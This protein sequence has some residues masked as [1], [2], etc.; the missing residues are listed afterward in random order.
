MA[1]SK[2]EYVKEF[3]ENKRILPNSYFVVRIDG[4]GFTKFSQVHKFAKP[5]DTNALALMTACASYVMKQ[6][7]DI[8]FAYG[9]S[10]EY[11]FLFRR[12][13]DLWN[14]R[15]MKIAGSIVS[16]FSAR[17][18]MNWESRFK[19][20]PL[21]STPCF[22]TRVVV[23]PTKNEVRDYFSWRQADCHVNNLY[24]YCFWSLVNKGGFTKNEAHKKLMG[25]L[26]KDKN[27]LL[28]S[29]YGINYSKIPEIERKGTSLIRH[30]CS[31]G[32]EIIGAT[33]EDIINDS[34]W[35]THGHILSIW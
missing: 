33:Y 14:R 2:F 4:R 9:Q 30:Q 15:E 1:C 31:S 28:F 10:D 26:A 3:E 34:F 7:P 13:T 16:E 18:V 23:Y 32:G 24:N 19:D 12:G 29:D 25:T 11:S 17:Y 20:T 27:E 6:F 21:L 5:N 22:D 35:E 8:I